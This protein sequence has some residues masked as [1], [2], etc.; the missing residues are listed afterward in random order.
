MPPLKEACPSVDQPWYT[1]NVGA[2]AKFAG[3]QAYFE[4]L[5]VE[6]PKH[7]YFPE[8]LKSIMIMKE[9]NH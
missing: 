1:N 3:I 4:R 8:S 9:H 5:Q 2:G 7:G 6:G